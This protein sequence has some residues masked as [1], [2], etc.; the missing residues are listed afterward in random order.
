MRERSR[1][2]LSSPTAH[3]R[4]P[5]LRSRHPSSPP[6]LPWLTASSISRLNCAPPSVKMRASVCP[7]ISSSVQP[8]IRVAPLFQLVMFP[9]SSVLIIAVS[10]APSTIWRHC[11]AV[12]NRLFS[13]Y[14]FP[15]S[16]PGRKENGFPSCRPDR[17]SIRRDLFGL[18]RR[19][20]VCTAPQNACRAPLVPRPSEVCRIRSV[21]FGIA[22]K[23][24]RNYRPLK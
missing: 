20:N 7:S 8:R 22:G 3:R 23:F 24:H 5:S 15:T 18:F 14:S 1:I 13:I 21:V 16:R 12:I 2:G 17:S 9:C 11:D 4:L 19:D 6:P 10:V